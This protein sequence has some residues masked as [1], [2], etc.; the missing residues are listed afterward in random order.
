MSRP[1]LETFTFD[2]LRMVSCKFAAFLEGSNPSSVI[3]TCACKTGDV[4]RAK[5]KTSQ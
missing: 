1:K 2:V 3:L 4:S 5:A